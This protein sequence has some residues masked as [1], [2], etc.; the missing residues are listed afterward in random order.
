MDHSERVKSLLKDLK[1]SEAHVRCNALKSFRSLPRNLWVEHAL[2]LAKRLWDPVGLVRETACVVLQELPPDELAK[3]APQL[4][5][6]LE[7][8]NPNVRSAAGDAFTR[9]PPDELA[10]YVAELVR[11]RYRFTSP[12]IDGALL[13]LLPDTDD[14]D[15]YSLLYSEEF[16]VMVLAKFWNAHHRSVKVLA[17]REAMQKISN[18]RL[19]KCSR[20][21]VK[22]WRDLEEAG[23]WDEYF[24]GSSPE[25]CEWS[26]GLIF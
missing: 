7:D 13:S 9:I 4:L 20:Q 24:L 1:D 17:A 21:L 10:K 15:L 14:I 2:E 6:S 26:T 19:A 23:R 3:Y 5:A 12:E 8:E 25:T 16:V 11:A 22:V 18:S